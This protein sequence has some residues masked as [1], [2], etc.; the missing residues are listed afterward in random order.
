[1]PP[2]TADQLLHP[3]RP[4]GDS[5][6][7]LETARPTATAPGSSSGFSFAVGRALG[8]VVVTLRGKLDRAGAAA[9]EHALRDLIHDQGNL[10]VMIDLG[11]LDSMEPTFAAVLASAREWACQLGGRFELHGPSEV[12]LATI[13]QAGLVD[14]VPSTNHR[15]RPTPGRSAA[16]TTAAPSGRN[17]DATSVSTDDQRRV[18][19]A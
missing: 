8:T 12:A 19:I 17:R 4:S 13:H 16:S 7:G 1:M 3:A 10:S 14:V 6:N 2:L 15:R 9:L 11:N 18:A 5:A